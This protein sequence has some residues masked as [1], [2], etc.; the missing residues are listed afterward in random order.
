[1][2]KF[3]VFMSVCLLALGFASCY[4]KGIK[5]EGNIVSET[6]I[7]GD[8]AKIE[9]NGSTDVTVVQ[10]DEYYVIVKGYSNL[11][12]I[13]KTK[14]NGDRL[15]LEFKEGYWNVRNDNITVEVHTPYVDK[16]SLNGSGSIY[17]GSGYDHER[18]DAH[19]NG[20]GNI[21]VGKSSFKYMDVNING[22]GNYNSESADVNNVYV[23]ISGSG[24]AY[25]YV[26]DYLKVRISGSGDVYYR[27]NPGT[28]DLDISGSGQVHKRS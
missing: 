11:V 8:F 17:V 13:Y 23:K 21:E 15:I 28:V 9:A 20:S 7:V 16:V 10:D 24:D 3:T 14:V 27:G 22:S 19:I 6:R 5:G 18:L 2:K 1:M 26:I 25:V 4:K 12:P